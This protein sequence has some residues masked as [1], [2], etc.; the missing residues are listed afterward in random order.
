MGA[1]EITIIS[2]DHFELDDLDHHPAIRARIAKTLQ[3][4]TDKLKSCRPDQLITIQAW[5]AALEWVLKVPEIVK[6]E[7]RTKRKKENHG[8]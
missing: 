1:P 6:Q 5:I 2:R 8:G 3:D 4:E 7:E